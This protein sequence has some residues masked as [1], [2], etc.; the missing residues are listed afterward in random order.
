MAAPMID[1][2]R[3]ASYGQAVPGWVDV[4]AC[5]LP[6]EPF[7]WA[8][9]RDGEMIDAHWQRCRAETPGL[10]NGETYLLRDLRIEDG[11]LSASMFR[12]DFK[13]LLYW[14]S[15]GSPLPARE[16]F[17]AALL[18]S[19]E[20]HVLLGRQGPGQL[21]SGLIYPPSGVLC[22]ADINGAGETDID[23]SAAR[24]LHEETGLGPS[25]LQRMP[26]YRIAITGA[27][28]AIAI[29][30][31]SALPAVELRQRILD[32]IAREEAPELDDVVIVTSIDAIDAEVMPAHARLLLQSV[33]SA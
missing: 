23:A 9:A 13:S 16:A 6:V 30:W 2:H 17:G 33:L 18:R 19:A 21:H 22:D 10:F 15:L 12:T 24:E 7:D 8:I 14:R 5:R 1:S 4:A 28:V 11:A 26:G 29:E 25:A 32:F 31:R 20:G 27:E 3:I